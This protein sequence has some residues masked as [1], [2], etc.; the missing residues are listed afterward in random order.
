[1][2]E[3]ELLGAAA[4][5]IKDKYLDLDGAEGQARLVLDRFTDEEVA[6]ISRAV[7]ATPRSRR[8]SASASRDEIGGKAPARGRPHRG[9]HDRY[10]RSRTVADGRRIML[11]ANSDDE[12][13][14]S[15]RELCRHR[16]RAA[17]RRPRA[18]GATAATWAPPLDNDLR[19]WILRAAGLQQAQ[20]G[21]RR[22][23]SRVRQ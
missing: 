13:G 11:L 19:H 9:A 23:A 15:L 17:P 12:Q 20:P 7:L 1:V 8:T 4:A 2:N 3:H 14:Q 6:A 22:T 16:Q 5:Q 10:W 21:Q 18:L